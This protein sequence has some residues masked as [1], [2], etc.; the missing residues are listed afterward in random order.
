MLTHGF[1]SYINTIKTIFMESKDL[2]FTNIT[3]EIL[4]NTDFY[5][6]A[7]YAQLLAAIHNKSFSSKLLE[8][9]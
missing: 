1:I 5:K 8:A 2:Q 4:I 6:Q 9:F 7:F 3:P